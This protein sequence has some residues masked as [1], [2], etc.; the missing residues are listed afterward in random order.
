MEN[1]MEAGFIHGFRR[2]RQPCPSSAPPP[3]LGTEVRKR[4]TGRA[5]SSDIPSFTHQRKV[6]QGELMINSSR[7]LQQC[8]RQPVTADRGVHV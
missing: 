4:R 5:C 6:V 8:A 3:R 2:L 7:L 1:E